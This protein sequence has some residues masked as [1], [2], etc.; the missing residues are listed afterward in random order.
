MKKHRKKSGC[1]NKMPILALDISKLEL[2]WA[3]IINGIC[4]GLGV[5]ISAGLL[6]IFRTHFVSNL[7]KGLKKAYKKIKRK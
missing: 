1:L 3:M 6:Y 2:Y 5:G 4:T 7:L